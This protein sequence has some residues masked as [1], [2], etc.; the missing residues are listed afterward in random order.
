MFSGKELVYKPNASGFLLYSIGVNGIDEGGRW[1]G[2][3]PPGDD[4][5]VRIPQLPKP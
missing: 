4:I 1:A 3:H 5:A 2:D